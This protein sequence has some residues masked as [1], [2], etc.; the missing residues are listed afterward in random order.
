MGKR[1]LQELILVPSPSRSQLEMPQPAN[2]FEAVELVI[3]MEVKSTQLIG[4]TRSRVQ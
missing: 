4:G 1:W 3:L 2:S